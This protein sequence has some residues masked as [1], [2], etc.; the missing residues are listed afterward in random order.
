MKKIA[1][2]LL[3]LLAT[4]IPSLPHGPALA[5][6]KKPL[7]IQL[8]A[9]PNTLDPLHVGDVIGYNIIAS[10]SEGLVRLDAEGKLQ[11]GLAELPKVSKDGRTYRFTLREGMKWSDGKAVTPQDFLFGLRTALSPA[12]ATRDASLLSSINAYRGEGREIVIELKAPDTSVLQAL[13][14]PLAAPLR[15]DFWK[16]RK[17]WTSDL[18][19][20]GPYR[21]KRHMP[22]RE[23]LL[24][25][26]PHY[27]GAAERGPILFRVV[28]EETTALN[29]FETGGLDVLTTV[30]PTELA[31]L[32]QAGRIRT[33]PSA[34]V[35]YLSWDLTQAPFRDDRWRKAVAGAVERANL[36]RLQ[37]HTFTETKSYLPR[38]L[39]FPASEAG[40]FAAEVAWAKANP[41]PAPVPLVY[42][43]TNLSHLVAQ[44]LQNDLEKSLGLQTKLEPLEW[45]SY[46]GRL[47]SNPP[48]FSTRAT[49]RPSTTPSAT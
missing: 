32:E 33:S 17:R 47:N 43:A 37:S 16:A 7:V 15:E 6:D 40:P 24:E 9:E 27:A 19:S 42:A 22:D 34:V 20:T 45:K 48:A 26:N 18:P 35:Y 5:A 10:V 3:L 46:L 39:G 12:T 1:L 2:A 21:I 29:L 25:P 13:A 23:V 41:L 28:P 14:M 31:R 4:L 11:P 30:P 44:R 49:A 36:S 8:S 38:S